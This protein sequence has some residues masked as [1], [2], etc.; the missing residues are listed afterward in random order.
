[1]TDLTNPLGGV[2]IPG[3]KRRLVRPDDCVMAVGGDGCVRDSV[4][5]RVNFARFRPILD[6]SDADSSVFGYCDRAAAIL[7]EPYRP[8]SSGC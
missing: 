1:M 2:E 5:P 6:V 7:R 3:L 4:N 8:N